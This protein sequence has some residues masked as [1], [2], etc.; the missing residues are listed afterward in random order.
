MPRRIPTSAEL[1]AW[2]EFIEASELVTSRVTARLQQDAG[3][4]SGDYS[5]LLA[6]SEAE[7]SVLRSSHLA[8]RIAWERSR[9]SGHLGRMEKR[10][11]IRREP[12][13]EDARGSM[14]VLTDRGSAAFHGSTRSHFEAISEI[15]AAALTPEQLVAMQDASAALRRHHRG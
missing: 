13:P 3:L 2:R 14:V 10:G 4:S 9:L 5:V 8:E 15:F 6:L 1:A 7:G 11:L 12:C